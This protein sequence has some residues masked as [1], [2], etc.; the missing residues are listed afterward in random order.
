MNILEK[1]VL[2]LKIEL[3]FLLEQ[4]LGWRKPKDPINIPKYL[5]KN[6]V[7]GDS[8]IIDCGAHIGS[9]SVELAKLFPKAQIH[10]FEP[11]PTLFK[12]LEYAT[13]KYS[14]IQR[15]QLALSNQTGE[16]SFFI[17]T[18][19]SDA[20]SSLLAPTG[21]LENHKDVLFLENITVPTITLDEWA[22]KNFISKVDIL[23]LDMQGFELLMLQASHTILKTVKAIHTEVSLKNSYD[24]APLYPAYK[25]WLESQGF[26][27]IIEAI[28]LDSD[29]GNVLFARK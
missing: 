20:S 4:K 27:I 23:W 18:G 28:P 12:N 14:N 26:T 7:I 22:V 5:M 19:S 11:I 3:A 21:H 1:I 13:R 9:D 29:M 6:Y 2:K 16:A 24:G 10:S 8:I 17:S 15:H 25:D